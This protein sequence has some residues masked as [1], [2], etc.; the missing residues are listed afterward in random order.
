VIDFRYHLVSIAAVF[1]A[2]AVGIVLGSGPLKDDISGFLEDRTAQL[3]KEKVDLQHQISALRNDQSAYEDFAKL[4]QPVLVE[5][6]LNDRVVTLFVLPDAS[7]DQV[8]AVKSAIEEGGGTVGEEVEIK[9][10]WSDPG[11]RDVLARVAEDV[12]KGGRANDTYALASEALAQAVMVP[13]GRATGD[14]YQEG[15]LTLGSFEQAGLISADEAEVIRGDAAV[16]VGPATPVTDADLTL[17][18]LL[19]ALD[20]AGAG[21]V[22][23]APNGSAD[24][25]GIVAA[26]RASDANG[27]VSSVDRLDTTSGVTVT[28]LALAEQLAGGVGQYGTGPDANGP[29]PDPLPR[30]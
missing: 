2:L 19:S 6:L 13:G 18:P 24:G 20:Q 12:T 1:L 27:T 14:P 25:D 9:S 16:V 29:A 3:A 5:N 11:Q 22:L 8:N 10:A 21:T 23:A 26:L 30:G 17:V 7:G 15:G 28:I 4:T